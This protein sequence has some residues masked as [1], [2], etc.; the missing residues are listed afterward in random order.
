MSRMKAPTAKEKVDPS[1]A[2]PDLS[3]LELF[4]LSETNPDPEF[5]LV[6][7]A[8]LLET[9]GGEK[10]LSYDLQ[11]WLKEI[12]LGNASIQDQRSA[13]YLASELRFP[14]DTGRKAE[15]GIAQLTA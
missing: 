14:R 11:G 5:A 6:V 7:L 1:A 8:N 12:F 9:T 15:G 2:S 4:P 10:E 3:D 13:N